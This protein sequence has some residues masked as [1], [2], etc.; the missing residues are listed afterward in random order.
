MTKDK[1]FHFN[2]GNSS[3]GS[4][5]FCARIKAKNSKQAVEILKRALEWFNSEVDVAKSTGLRGEEKN[6]E[7]IQA[8][9]NADAISEKDI[10]EVN[11]IE[12]VA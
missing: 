12:E 9:F 7:Y 4:I 5:G 10:D 1:S 6:V 8:Y 11:P 2:L 3:V